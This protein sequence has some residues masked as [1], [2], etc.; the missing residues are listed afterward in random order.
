[1]DC[2]SRCCIEACVDTDRVMSH[3][4][5]G[6]SQR[7]PQTYFSYLLSSELLWLLDARKQVALHSGSRVTQVTRLTLHSNV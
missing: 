6:C 1:M 7:M 2:L 4:I 5:D 3:S